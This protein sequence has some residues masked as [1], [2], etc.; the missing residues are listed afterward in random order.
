MALHTAPRLGFRQFGDTDDDIIMQASLKSASDSGPDGTPVGADAAGIIHDS[1]KGVLMGSR[2]ATIRCMQPSAEQQ[3]QLVR[4]GTMTIWVETAWL[5]DTYTGPSG[6]EGVFSAYSP[7]GNKDLTVRKH[8]TYQ[9][10]RIF[11]SEN[12][13]SGLKTMRINGVTKGEYSRVDLSWH[14]SKTFLYIDYLL[15]A[16]GLY[17]ALSTQFEEIYA[18][19]SKFG[20]G[21]TTHYVKD[22]MLST[23]PIALAYDYKLAHVVCLGHSFDDIGDY[24]TRLNNGLL[25][26]LPYIGDQ[27]NGDAGD[28]KTSSHIHRNLAK[29]G[30]GIGNGYIRNTAVGGSKMGTISDHLNAALNSATLHYTAQTANFTTTDTVTGGTSLVAATIDVQTDVGTTGMLNVSNVSRSYGYIEGETITDGSGGSATLTKVVTHPSTLTC[31]IITMGT[32]DINAG[33]AETWLTTSATWES[34]F[35]AEL[36]LVIAAGA[37]II[38]LPECVTLESRIAERTEPARTSVKLANTEV[39]AILARLAAANTQVHVV[40]LFDLFGGFGDAP[41]PLMADFASGT[42]QNDVHPNDSGYKII[43]DEIS[44]KLLSLL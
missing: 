8:S 1:V 42:S 30:K 44:K 15:M 25:P 22:F 40:P 10:P 41:F 13:D 2:L 38:L 19:G 28:E 37:E 12:A 21:M 17:S 18:A 33:D 6:I 35:Q 27:A 5:L 7:T 20:L 39:N 9:W 16:S 32:N 14:G 34:D 3:A 36:D 4:G 43:G 26:D 23:Q 24:A 31:A 29:A 11:E